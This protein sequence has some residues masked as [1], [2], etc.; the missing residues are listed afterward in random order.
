MKKTLTMTLMFVASAA[1]AHDPI[2]WNGSEIQVLLNRE[3]T[4]GDMGIFTTRFPGPGGPPRHVHEDAGEALY[5][6]EGSAEF[7]A[8][9]NTFVLGEGE[10]AFVQKGVDHTFRI[11]EED[12]GKLMVIVAPG[13]FEGF[14]DA[15]KHLKLP[16]E[17]ETLNTISAE[18]GQV[19]TGPPLEAE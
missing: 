14:F 3:E 12:G 19:F 15:T 2:D 8:D 17:I 4:G 9:G 6:M 18:Y 16:D 13:G 11:L 5:V 10:I 7:L 1:A